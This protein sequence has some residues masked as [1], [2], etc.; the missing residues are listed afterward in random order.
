MDRYEQLRAKAALHRPAERR[1]RV[2]RHA[3]AYVM[4]APVGKT[5]ALQALPARM[6]LPGPQ[7]QGPGSQHAQAARADFYNSLH[8]SSPLI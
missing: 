5:D 2:L 6:I 3:F 1:H 4:E 7:Q 8:Q